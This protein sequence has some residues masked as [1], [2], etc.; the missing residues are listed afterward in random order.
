MNSFTKYFYNSFKETKGYVL[1]LLGIVISIIFWILKPSDTIDLKIFIP[2]VIIL[3]LL[4]II[5]FNL[6]YSLFQK[7][8]NLNPKVVQGRQPPKFQKDSKALLLLEKSELFSQDAVVALF[9]NDEG[10]ERLI[11]AGFVL[12]IQ[13]NGIIQV[14]ISKALDDNDDSIWNKLISN[15]SVAINKILVKPNVP[16]ILFR[17]GI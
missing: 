14:V 7:S 5:L 2:I 9:Y 4:L 17:R 13:N 1:A 6:S 10:Y 16:K 3:L 8:Q 12:S 11:G 15:D